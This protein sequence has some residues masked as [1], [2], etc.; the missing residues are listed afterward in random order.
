MAISLYMVAGGIP[1]DEW[2]LLHVIVE[3]HLNCLVDYVLQSLKG[4]HTM[5]IRELYQQPSA[6]AVSGKT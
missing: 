6:S 5:F 2:G 4:A 1:I 3:M